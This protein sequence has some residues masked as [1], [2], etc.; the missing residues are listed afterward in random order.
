MHSETPKSRFKIRPGMSARSAEEERNSKDVF[1]QMR[2]QG[3]TAARL[4][5]AEARAARGP[6]SI[7]WQARRGEALAPASLRSADAASAQTYQ[8][9]ESAQQKPAT[10]LPGDKSS[11]SLIRESS[12]QPAAAP[13]RLPNPATKVVEVKEDVSLARGEKKNSTTPTSPLQKL[14][15]LFLRKLPKTGTPD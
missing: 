15:A 8:G 13:E 7:Q 10:S 11:R 4:A 14:R 2:I 5:E 3:G 6:L 9:K 12:R 1:P